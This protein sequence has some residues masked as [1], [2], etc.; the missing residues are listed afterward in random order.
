VRTALRPRLVVTVLAV[1]VVGSLCLTWADQLVRSLYHHVEDDYVLCSGDW[2]NWGYSCDNAEFTGPYA[3][4]LLLTVSA[5]MFSGLLLLGRWTLAPLRQVTGVVGRF[6]PQNLVERIGS[7]GRRDELSRLSGE[8][9][10][11]LDRVAAG[12]EGQRRFA[13]NASHE[14][15][16]PLAVQRTLVE[17]GLAGDPTPQQLELLARQLLQ[18]NQRNESL[19]EGLLVL[20][21]SDQGLRSRTAQRLDELAAD[22][23]ALHADAAR[24]A[25]VAL[26]T[27]LAPVTVAGEAALLERLLANL[28]SN[29][30]KYNQAGGEVCVQVRAAQPVLT[31]SNTG[32]VV[33]AEAVPGL[34]EPFRRARGDRLD[35][36][37][38]AGLGLTIARSISTAHGGLIDALARSDGGLAV[39]VELPPGP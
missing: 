11:M 1:L 21:E 17:V 34:F 31:V 19:V 12:Y 28:V 18:A 35:H 8:I 36:T 25:G 16:T 24:A 38:G 4:T 23:V 30:I 5:A 27:D 33:A 7:R 32:P 22:A 9:D 13:G 3:L 6:G 10:L 20:A 29:G 14:L 26:R 15:R 37:G 2:R 39:T